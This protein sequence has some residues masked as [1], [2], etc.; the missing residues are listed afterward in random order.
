MPRQP[1]CF[2]GAFGKDTGADSSCSVSAENNNIV[3][4]ATK[5]L[6]SG[7]TL[8]VV[9]GFQ[10]GYFSG[11]SFADYFAEYGAIL[12]PIIFIPLFVGIYAFR[13]WRKFGRDPKGAMTVVPEYEAPDKLRPM[14]VGTLIDF[15][16]DN[17]DMSATIVD[18]AIRGFH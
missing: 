2:A 14:E 18:L 4:N 3:I 12:I 6:T 7:E 16:A 17:A 5:S 1:R 8:T 10:K 9:A 15:R 13:R 11:Y